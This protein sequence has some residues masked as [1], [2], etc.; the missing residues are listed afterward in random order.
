ME[1]TIMGFKM[2]VEIIV[3]CILLGGFIGVNLFCTC[4]GGVKESFELIGSA[5]DYTMGDGIKTS[6][7]NKKTHDSGDY[8]SSL[9]K[10]LEGNV[11]GEVPLPETEMIMFSKNKFAPECCPSV[12]SSSTGCVCASPEQMKYL[13]QRGGNRTLTSEY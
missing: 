12:Y 6:W 8:T 9:Y 4:A 3:L 11:G 13:N 5:L 1:L 10:T 7:E 2:R